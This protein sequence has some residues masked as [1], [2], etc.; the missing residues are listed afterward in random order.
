M[1]IRRIVAA[2]MIVVS[3][4]TAGCD[5]FTL[6]SGSGQLLNIRKRAILS[7]GTDTTATTNKDS[8]TTETIT[9][10]KVCA[11]P[12]PDA[13]SAM[14]MEAAAKGGVPNNVS[15]ELSAALQQSAAFVGL[16]TAS[17]QLLRDF[18]YRLCEAYL[19]GA[20]TKGQYDLLMRR[21][22]KN[23]VALLAIEQLTG[24]VKAPPVV[25][26]TRGHAETSQSLFDQQN[27][28]EKVSEKIAALEKEKKTKESEKA[29]RLK[30]N[31]DTKELDSQ[32]ADKEA[33]I[34]GRKEDLAAIDKGIASARGTLTRGQTQATIQA[35]SSPAQRSDD[36]QKVADIVGKITMA[37]VKSDDIA[38]ECLLT[39]LSKDTYKDNS[40]AKLV[41]WCQQELDLH[42]R[43]KGMYFTTPKDQAE[44]AEKVWSTSSGTAD[45]RRQTEKALKNIQV[46]LGRGKK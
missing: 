19:S 46:E 36:I 11:E 42:Q 26:T 22:Q 2:S 44:T 5:S 41:T 39:L 25:L 21:F 17:I 8:G 4:F 45:K 34:T 33:E 6:S 32:L 20:L 7:G 10:F 35:D 13:M 30:A 24:A 18:G 40:L 16:R 28:R 9:N 14:A 23:V 29:D 38:Q 1:I 37:I 15:V 3:L 43:E 27:V 31:A 12:S